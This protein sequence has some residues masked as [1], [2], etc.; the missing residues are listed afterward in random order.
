MTGKAEGWARVRAAS[1]IASRARPRLDP[2]LHLLHFCLDGRHCTVFATSSALDNRRLGKA[3]MQL[4]R[5]LAPLGGTLCRTSRMRLAAA[6][7]YDYLVFRTSH[8][9]AR[10][11]R[12]RETTSLTKIASESLFCVFI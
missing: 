11:R 1:A 3:S 8:L 2:N 5:E 9:S 12:E 7:N 10:A 4:S 6:T